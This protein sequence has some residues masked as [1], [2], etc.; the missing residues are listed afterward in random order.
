MSSAIPP[1]GP[2]AAP[3]LRGSA[4]LLLALRVRGLFSFRHHTTS[5][6]GSFHVEREDGTWRLTADARL[7]IATP[8]ASH[9]AA[10]LPACYGSPV[11]SASCREALGFG[12]L[13]CDAGR[14]WRASGDVG[15][16]FYNFVV[17]ELASWFSVDEWKTAWE[18][19]GLGFDIDEIWDDASSSYF[20]P[21]PDTLI[22]PCFCG[23][24]MGPTW[25]VYFANASWTS[26]FQLMIPRN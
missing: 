19:I 2:T 8:S 21:A 13:A 12:G 16:C 25:A 11:L 7:P 23:I 24:Y 26:W 9:P 1:L 22:T 15:D 6:V 17:E 5:M 14:L 18:W 20:K 4:Q 10:G 3:C